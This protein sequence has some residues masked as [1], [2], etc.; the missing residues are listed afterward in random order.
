MNIAGS[1]IEQIEL[2]QGP[3]FLHSKKKSIYCHPLNINGCANR[4]S[5][6][7]IL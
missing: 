5:F 6:G 2:P 7:I 3:K 4:I 1:N